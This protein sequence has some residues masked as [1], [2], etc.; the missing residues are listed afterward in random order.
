M[1]KIKISEI[2]DLAKILS[3][4][5]KID[6]YH[7]DN[8]IYVEKAGLLLGMA[9]SKFMPF[10]KIIPCE[11]HRQLSKTKKNNSTLLSKM[12]DWFII[13]L[14]KFEVN[15]K[16]YKNKKK[17]Y[18]EI[19]GIINPAENYLIVDDSLDTGYTINELVDKL[20]QLGVERKNI[21][22]AVINVLSMPKL[23]PVILPDYYIYKNIHIQYPWSADSIEYKK[24]QEVY[25][26]F[27]K[28]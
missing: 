11:A 6:N 16:L 3:D 21:K 4:K 10:I 8:L 28:K 23:R 13:L 27:F 22:I 14:R 1:L 19:K 26:V 9:I 25:C 7:P 20:L 12:P 2:D 18:L 15:F 5:V 17:R 24:Y